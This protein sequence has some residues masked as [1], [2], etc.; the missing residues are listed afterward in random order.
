MALYETK[1]E[2]ELHTDASKVG[3]AGI[4]MQRNDE[5]ALKPVAYYSRKTTTDKQKWH[6]YDLETL[7]VIEA[8]RRF[9][10]Y[11][12]GLKFKI[13]TDCNALRTVLTKRDLVPRIARWWI[14]LQEYDC[15]IEYRP[16]TR[17]AH[18]DALSRNLVIELNANIDECALDV[19]Q[20]DVTN[21][22]A[23]VQS[24]DEEIGKIKEILE[25]KEVGHMIDVHKNYKIKGGHVYR[26]V[27]VATPRAN[28]HGEKDCTWDEYVGG[29]QLAINTTTNE[30]TGK[31]S[32]ELLFGCKLINASENIISDV[33]YATKHR[34]SSDD[35]A[36][37]RTEANERIQRQQNIAEKRFNKQ[38]RAPTPYKVGDLVRIERTPTDQ[39]MLGQP[40][41]LV[42]RFQGPYRI[43]KILPNDR[44][45]VEDTPITRRGN[46][47]YENVVA[48]DKLHPWLNFNDSASDD[49]NSEYNQEN[50]KESEQS[51]INRY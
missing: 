31:S 20:I 46:K 11:L 48:I 38:R 28:G 41:K 44:F 49:S 39:A 21:W 42:A 4:L 12:L 5:G 27:N 29:I 26:Q 10:V 30:T 37:M 2:T 15:E 47:R 25:H 13:I 23:T 36:K 32:S 22:I 8:L 24:A 33:I 35:L 6:S 51:M 17:M 43:T 3:I 1:R 40:K 14:R 34:V 19:L 16:G 7:A 50:G 18:V 45:L 9:R